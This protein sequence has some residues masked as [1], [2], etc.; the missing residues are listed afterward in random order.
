MRVLD[1]GSCQNI[2]DLFYSLVFFFFFLP[3]SQIL[4]LALCAARQWSPFPD[5]TCSSNLATTCLSLKGVWHCS[6]ISAWDS[7]WYAPSSYQRHRFF[8]FC[9]IF[10]FFSVFFLLCFFFCCL[11]FVVICLFC[12]CCFSLFSCFWCAGVSFASRRNRSVWAESS[13]RRWIGKVCPPPT[14]VCSPESPPW[15]ASSSR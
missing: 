14:A 7:V 12:R 2:V 10:F 8:P 1:A 5:N 3:L 9:C 11:T 13:K 4:L 15:A 6:P